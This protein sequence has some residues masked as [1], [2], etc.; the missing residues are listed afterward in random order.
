M[1]CYNLDLSLANGVKQ[2]SDTPELLREVSVHMRFEVAQ[3]K[4]TGGFNT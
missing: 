4:S 3:N 1:F 2:S